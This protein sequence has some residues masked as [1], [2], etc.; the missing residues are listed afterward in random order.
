MEEIEYKKYHGK[1]LPPGKMKGRKEGRKISCG[2]LERNA[3]TGDVT[4]K[5]QTV[6]TCCKLVGREN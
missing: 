3:A 1:R 4:K 5:A 6:A 2:F